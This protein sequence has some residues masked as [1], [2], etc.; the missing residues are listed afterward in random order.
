MEFIQLLL[1][2]QIADIFR[3]NDN[4][5]YYY[6]ESRCFHYSKTAFRIYMNTIISIYHK[7]VLNVFKWTFTDKMN[8]KV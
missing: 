7:D 4:I 3:A 5:F 1:A 8:K 6:H 2:N